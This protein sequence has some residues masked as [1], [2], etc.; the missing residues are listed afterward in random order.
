MRREDGEAETIRGSVTACPMR[1]ELKSLPK[2]SRRYDTR[3]FIGSWSQ[4]AR[5]RVEGWSFLDG[6]RLRVKCHDQCFSLVNGVES[7]I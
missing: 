7:L 2:D 6:T 1:R 5:H 3:T 4:L